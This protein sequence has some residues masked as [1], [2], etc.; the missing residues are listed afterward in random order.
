MKD[1]R[2]ILSDLNSGSLNVSEIPDELILQLSS[3]MLIELLEGPDELL[4]RLSRLQR[5]VLGLQRLLVERD[6]AKAV[7]ISE[8]LLFRSRS[9]EERDLECEVRIRMERALL[10]VDGIDASGQE[11]RW[12]SERLKAIAPNTALHGISMLNQANWHS[13]NGEIM[14]AMA[15]HAEIT[16]DS[17]FP[18]EIRGLSRLEVGRILT[19]MDDLDPAMRHLWT[20]R[21]IFLQA[22]MEAEAVVVSLEWL[23]LALEE[24]TEDAP[25]MLYRIENAGPRSVPGSSWV[26]ANEQDVRDVVE[27]IFSILTEDVGG[28][29]RTDLGIILDAAEILGEQEWKNSLLEMSK[30]IQDARLLEALQS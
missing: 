15:I 11:L 14:M 13:N 12:C 24:V 27:S 29:E 28:T 9:K 8:D 20:A 1:I 18:D 21:A 17:G 6:I 7:I 26:P 3:S 2:K 10:A 4:S 23:D 30:D 16:K 22:E 19:A 5:D 25:R